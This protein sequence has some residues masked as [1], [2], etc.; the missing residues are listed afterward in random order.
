MEG[1]GRAEQN[2]GVPEVWLAMQPGKQLP[3][4]GCAGSGLCWGIAH[5]HQRDPAHRVWN[6][7]QPIERAPDSSPCCLHGAATLRGFFSS[8][9]IEDLELEGASFLRC[10]R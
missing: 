2:S 9:Y 8:V 4:L 1:T 3:Q 5:A 7:G 10:W 6:M